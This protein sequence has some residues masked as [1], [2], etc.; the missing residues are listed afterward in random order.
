MSDMNPNPPKK[1]KPSKLNP[2]NYI[3]IYDVVWFKGKIDL[4]DNSKTDLS[5]KIIISKDKP[6]YFDE[7][8]VLQTGCKAYTFFKNYQQYHEMLLCTPF[9]FRNNQTR[10]FIN[11][12][13]SIQ[14]YCG[15]RP[16]WTHI[17]QWSSIDIPNTI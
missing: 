1:Q 2:S 6:S 10:S 5:N 17:E 7:K 12:F 15:Y 13:R 3:N 16:T 11:Y 9:V 4:V 14:N 8:G